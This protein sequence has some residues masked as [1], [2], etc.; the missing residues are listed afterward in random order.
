[1]LTGMGHPLLSN[2]YSIISNPKSLF[3]MKLTITFTQIGSTHEPLPSKE[4]FIIPT[5][6]Y[7]PTYKYIIF[8]FLA[9]AIEI[10]W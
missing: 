1:M 7:C 8:R 3:N 4:W 9:W 10:D 5:I 2:S 6:S